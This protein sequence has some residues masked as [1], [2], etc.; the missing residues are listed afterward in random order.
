[1]SDELTKT[2]SGH[3]VDASGRKLI[4]NGYC[5]DIEEECFCL[6]M[7]TWD[8]DDSD[9]GVEEIWTIDESRPPADMQQGSYMRLFEDGS[10]EVFAPV[11]TAE[12][13]AEIKERAKELNDFFDLPEE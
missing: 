11:W 10:L 6:V 9:W 13:I 8:D 2:N 1:M 7:K 5:H 12:E 3:Y 4:A